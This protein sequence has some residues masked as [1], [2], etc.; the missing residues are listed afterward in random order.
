MDDYFRTL[1]SNL[2][3]VNM[4]VLLLPPPPPPMLCCCTSGKCVHV[5]QYLAVPQVGSR[6][7]KV[8]EEELRTENLRLAEELAKKQAL[9]DKLTTM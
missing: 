1:F 7:G 9:I 3:S 6:Y 8:S 2:K 5:P 4:V